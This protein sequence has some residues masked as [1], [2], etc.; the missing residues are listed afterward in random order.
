MKPTLKRVGLLFIGIPIVSPADLP[1]FHKGN[2]VGAKGRLAWTVCHSEWSVRG[3]KN[4]FHLLSSSR[5]FTP[6]RMTGKTGLW[7]SSLCSE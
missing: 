4:P 1:P 5:F 3:M 2:K 7:D 6:F